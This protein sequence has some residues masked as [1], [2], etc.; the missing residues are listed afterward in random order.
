MPRPS[1]FEHK[2]F[3]VE[4]I[5][6]ED[7]EFSVAYGQWEGEVDPG[8]RIG[9]R[10]NGQGDDA[11]YPKLFQHPVWFMLPE[12]LTVSTLRGLQDQEHANRQAIERL[13]GRLTRA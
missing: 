3:P 12:H 10:W 1:D 8:P 6:Y 9:M 7:E 13:L 11:G 4:E 2:K 5:L